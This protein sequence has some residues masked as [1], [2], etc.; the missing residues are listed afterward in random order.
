[1]EPESPLDYECM[2]CLDL[3][4]SPVKCNSCKKLLCEKHM[5]QLANKCP[6][7][8]VEPFKISA[9]ESIEFKQ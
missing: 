8:R 4:K 3:L 2:V 5:I 6:H 9:E 1:M 7:C